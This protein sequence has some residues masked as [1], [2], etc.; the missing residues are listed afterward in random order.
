GRG[1]FGDPRGRR[2]PFVSQGEAGTVGEAATAVGA[3]V[4]RLDSNQDLADAA[5]LGGKGASLV[6]LVA[7]GHRVPPGLVVTVDAFR[8]ARA[9]LG[10]TD[11]LDLLDRTLAGGGD[12]HPVGERIAALLASSRLPSDV[13]APIE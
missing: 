2:G 7:Q 3:F 10:L 8:S 13:L 4:T 1:R 9:R 12:P 6:R 11:D 5:Q